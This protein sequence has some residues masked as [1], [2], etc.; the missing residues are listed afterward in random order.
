MWAASKRVTERCGKQPVEE[1]GTRVGKLVEDER[2]A[3]HLGEDREQ[4][5]AGRRL[6]H[7]IGRRER[8]RDGRRQ[9][10]ARSASRI[11]EAPGS[12]RSG[13]YARAATPRA[14]RAWRA[15]R[16]ASRH[17]PGSPGRICAGT[18][19]ARPRRRHR[20]ASSST[21]L[22]HRCRRKPRSMA[23]RSACASMVLAAFEVR[24]KE[25]GG[26]DQRR[27]HVRGRGCFEVKEKRPWR[28]PRLQRWES[29]A[30]VQESRNG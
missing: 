10:R 28:R 7:E 21:R 14:C 3:G 15:A 29:W 11:A 30:D 4:A 22:R 16:R 13:G 25:A 19:P 23:A 24:Q 8:G 27:S 9:S 12:P 26:A 18:E 1:T 6:Q 17:A 2:C 20:P 5:G